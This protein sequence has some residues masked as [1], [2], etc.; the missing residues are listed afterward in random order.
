MPLDPGPKMA[1]A[2]WIAAARFADP[3]ACDDEA[4]EVFQAH[5]SI[6]ATLN[7]HAVRAKGTIKADA[8]IPVSCNDAISE[9][10]DI[11]PQHISLQ[12][13]RS[14]LG[15]FAVTL[16]QGNG[17]G[18]A[19]RS[20]ACCAICG[21]GVLEIAGLVEVRIRQTFGRDTGGL[22]DDPVIEYMTTSTPFGQ[23]FA[24]FKVTGSTDTTKATRIVHTM[25]LEGQLTAGDVIDL[26]YTLHHELICH[27]F[28]G[29]R[30][31]QP[32][33]N[34]PAQCH[35]SEGWMDTMA[36]DIAERWIDDGQNDWVPLKGERGKGRLRAFHEYRYGDQIPLLRSDLTR[37]R[38]ARQSFH[39]LASILEQSGMADSPEEAAELSQTFTWMANTHPEAEWRRLKHLAS[40]LQQSLLSAIRNE[41]AVTA[42]Q[43][44]IAFLS[45]GDLS[46]LEKA[47]P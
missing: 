10:A 34:A 21:S 20:G 2:L 42:A 9:I 44:C 33:G 47:L 24:P 5:Q 18:R 3:H 38:N 4:E 32:K 31:G 17:D 13:L 6:F 28:Q 26:I 35:W 45:H 46:M 23:P 27:A 36:F 25:L 8:E 11:E 7:G 30:S 15:G 14:A 12:L 29:Y 41:D 39:A 1:T 43:A 22:G 37:R 19:C 16:V 40:R